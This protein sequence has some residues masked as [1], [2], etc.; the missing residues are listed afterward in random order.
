MPRKIRVIA[1]ELDIPRL[2]KEGH[3]PTEALRASAFGRR[4]GAEV[5][6]LIVAIGIQ[7]GRGDYPCADGGAEFCHNGS[8]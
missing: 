8:G 1:Y 6:W 5:A 2:E 7:V 4:N 3:I